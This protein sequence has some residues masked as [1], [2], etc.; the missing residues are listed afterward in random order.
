[1]KADEYD[2]LILDQS[3]FMLRKY[4][5][6]IFGSLRAFENLPT[7]SSIYSYSGFAKL[8]VLDTPAMAK[9]L[10]DLMTAAREAKRMVSDLPHLQIK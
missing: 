8:A 5:P 7:I 9:A 3:D 4:W 6:R 1:M 10:E 2:R